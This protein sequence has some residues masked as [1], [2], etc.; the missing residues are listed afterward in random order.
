L[1]KKS[2]YYNHF[3]QAFLK[4]FPNPKVTNSAFS[5]VFLENFEDRPH[6]M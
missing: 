4:Q 3:H 1:T 2:S 6:S 5:G